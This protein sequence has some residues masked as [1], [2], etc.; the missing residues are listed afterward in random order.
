MSDRFYDPGAAG[1]D[2]IFGFASRELAPTSSRLARVAPGHRVL[3]V[4]AGSGNA[5]QAAIHATGP[6]GEVVAVDI[7]APMLEE[8]R[9]RLGSFPNVAFAVEDGQALTLPDENFNAALC[10]LGLRFF[11][12]HAQG[13]SEFFRA[14]RRGGRAAASLVTCPDAQPTAASKRR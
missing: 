12:D 2:Q 9:K 10:G 7:S 13:V 14:L 4:A 11:P 8:A 5:A 1:Y 3:D 6:H